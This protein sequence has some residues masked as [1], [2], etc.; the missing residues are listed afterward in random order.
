MVGLEGDTRSLTRLIWAT[1]HIDQERALF[2]YFVNVAVRD[3]REGVA[4]EMQVAAERVAKEM[5]ATADAEQLHLFG[6]GP[7]EIAATTKLLDRYEDKFFEYWR[8]AI[9]RRAGP[10]EPS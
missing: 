2:D 1:P 3:Y 7:T 9:D 6:R 4:M 10:G 8:E 5:K